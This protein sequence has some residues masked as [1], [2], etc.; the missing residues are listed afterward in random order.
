LPEIDDVLAGP[1][2]TESKKPGLLYSAW[3]GASGVDAMQDVKTL[4]PLLS[5][6]LDI[7]LKGE[8][9]ISCLQYPRSLIFHLME[10]HRLVIANDAHIL[11]SPLLTA[12]PPIESAVVV[13]AGTGSVVV[14]F[15]KHA[16]ETS[17]QH[18][19]QF[20]RA[21]GWGFM[22]GDDGA[23]FFAGREAVRQVLEKFEA[24]SLWEPEEIDPPA[25]SPIVA[26]KQKE[27][28]TT[29]LL[30]HFGLSSPNELFSVVYAPDPKPGVIPMVNTPS[31]VCLLI[32]QCTS[33][34]SLTLATHIS[35][36]QALVERK[37]RL[38]A[39]APLVFK[40]AF[41]LEDPTAIRALR[42]SVGGLA[43]QAAS[44][45]TSAGESAHPGKRTVAAK[46]SIL[47]F[48]GSLFGVLR[49]RELFVDE[50][51]DIGQSFASVVYV[52]DAAGDGALGLAKLFRDVSP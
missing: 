38:V 51:K 37:Q 5:R 15:R 21:G 52:E 4:E 28:L 17:A 6:L 26:I 47:V 13:I 18:I 16:L 24:D 14:S 12:E 20:G 19:T 8:G 31:W 48:G 3:I 33:V 32:L 43:K 27:T 41:E 35:S 10:D 22:L 25:P 50:L 7:P 45:C 46:T 2:D 9:N 44:L 49:Y 42:V 23:G 36:L 11:A 1:H 40:A 30:S 34:H 39:L 29:L